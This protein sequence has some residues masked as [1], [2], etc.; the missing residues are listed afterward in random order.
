MIDFGNYKYGLYIGLTGA[1]ILLFFILYMV[2]RRRAVRSV[3][4]DRRAA[5]M[6]IS[7]SYRRIL[8]KEIL[9]I[10]AVIL[11]MAVLLRPRWGETVREVNREGSDVLIALDVSRSMLAREGGR[12]RLER[13]KG[14]VRWVAESLDGD[15]I[16]L[17]VFAGESF[18]L[19]PLTTDV[20]AFMLFLDSAGPDSVPL[21]GTDMGRMLL[22]A[23]K[24]FKKKR[25]TTKMLIVITDGEDH[26]GNVD[27]AADAFKEMGVS[28]Y[29]AGI[30]K[31]KGDFIP[32]GDDVNS[33]DVYY[34]DGDGKLIKTS[35]NRSLLKSLAGK[36]GGSY[37]NI[38][39]SYSGMKSVLDVIDDQQKNSFG[40]HIVKEKVE[41]TW[42]FALI[43]FLILAAEFVI[44]ERRPRQRGNP[45]E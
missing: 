32:A 44:M 2:W 17:L 33:A 37:M 19:C 16:G 15:R 31:D 13:A 23:G 3:I 18:L 24:V 45:A 21:Q 22:E 14:A 12:T 10:F 27:A 36:T 30:G 41:R 1:V 42:I 39:R 29:T 4:K 6:L 11:S 20:G 28:V 40:S 34:R 43:L 7:G 25:L 38:T 5:E 26:E 35:Q 8:A 9:I